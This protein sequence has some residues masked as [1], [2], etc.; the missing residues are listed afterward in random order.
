MVIYKCPLL[1]IVNKR[2]KFYSYYL[3]LTNLKVTVSNVNPEKVRNV[4]R[5]ALFVY[6]FS[7]YLLY[8]RIN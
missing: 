8:R 4:Y 6:I 1:L 3:T 5:T 2:T 7:K